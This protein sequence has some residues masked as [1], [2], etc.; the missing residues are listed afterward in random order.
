MKKSFHRA[1]TT[2]CWG[3]PIKEFVHFEFKDSF[4]FMSSSLE[5]L[6]KS[7]VEEDFTPLH[8]RFGENWKMLTTPVKW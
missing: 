7:L 5:V 3:H 1:N 6:S 4:H 8:E 2:N